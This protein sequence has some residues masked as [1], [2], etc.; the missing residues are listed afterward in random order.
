MHYGAGIF[1]GV[2]GSALFWLLDKYLLTW[3]QSYQVGGV[4][5]CFVVFGGAGYW[6]ALRAAPKKPEAPT[7]TRVATGLK[8]KNIKVT[9]DGVTATGGGS[10][11][12]LSD[13]DAKGDIEA[14]A[15]NIKTKP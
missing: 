8:G 1:A 13:V 12:I 9:V 5:A 6:L 10:A 7:G 4:I 3:P 15:K 2:T 11:D 14:D